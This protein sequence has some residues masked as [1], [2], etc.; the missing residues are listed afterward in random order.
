MDTRE[1]LS[2]VTLVISL[3]AREVRVR[4]VLTSLVT[5]RVFRHIQTDHGQKAAGYQFEEESPIKVSGN[6]SSLS[7]LHPSPTPQ[8]HGYKDHTEGFAFIEFQETCDGSF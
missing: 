2:S 3:R 1:H 5:Q 6:D 8:N 7:K 4:E